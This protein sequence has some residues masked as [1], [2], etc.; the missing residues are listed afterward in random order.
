MITEAL[1]SF[2]TGF[3]S[4]IAGIFPHWTA[5]D[6]LTGF[7]SQIQSIL[8][9]AQGLGVWLNFGLAGT[10]VVAVVGTWIVCFGIKLLLRIVSYV[11]LVG[12][13]G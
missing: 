9:P 4:F 8:N 1:I 12:G 6:W 10:V 7:G 5:P 3:V 11:P 2:G 13:A